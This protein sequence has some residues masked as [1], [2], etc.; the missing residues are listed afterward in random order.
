MPTGQAR[1]CGLA[2]TGAGTRAERIVPGGASVPQASRCPGRVQATYSRAPSPPRPLPVRC[3][4]SLDSARC[5]A[6]RAASMLSAAKP[7]PAARAPSARAAAP[8]AAPLLPVCL[9]QQRHAAV[10]LRLPSSCRRSRRRAAQPWSPPRAASEPAA[11]AAELAGA[12]ALETRTWLWRHEGAEHRISYERLAGTGAGPPVVVS[13]GFGS[14][15]R[16]FRRL[17]AAL[18]AAGYTVFAPDLLGACALR[19]RCLGGRWRALQPRP[20]QA[21]AR[22]SR[23]ACRS[24]CS[25]QR[26]AAV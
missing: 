11:D 1:T 9:R 20:A 15:A 5:V 23:H 8:A 2:I 10:P 19:Y 12:P 25:T 3:V 26:S 7:A 4:C 24:H 18:A 14:N 16:H 21:G 22:A 13:H 17:T 6:R